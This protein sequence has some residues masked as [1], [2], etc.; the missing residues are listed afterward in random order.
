MPSATVLHSAARDNLRI[1]FYFYCFTCLFCL[2]LETNFELNSSAFL[3][4]KFLYCFTSVKVVLSS[5]V[6]LATINSSIRLK[7]FELMSNG[8]KK[9]VV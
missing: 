6:L 7:L 4:N 9:Y 8:V 3:Y 5:E 1:E 2:R